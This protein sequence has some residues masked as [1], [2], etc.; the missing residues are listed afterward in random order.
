MYYSVLLVLPLI[1]TPQRDLGSLLVWVRIDRFIEEQ[2]IYYGL[3]RKC[4]GGGL[5]SSRG[6]GQGLDEIPVGFSPYHPTEAAN[7]KKWT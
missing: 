1:Q 5:F 4:Q 3:G 7:Q 2:K 6:P